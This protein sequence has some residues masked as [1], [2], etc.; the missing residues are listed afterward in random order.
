MCLIEFDVIDG[1][2]NLSMG[3]ASKIAASDRKPNE[4]LPTIYDVKQI[5]WVISNSSDLINGSK[6]NLSG[7]PAMKYLQALEL[8]KKKL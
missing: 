8:L 6:I 7:D 4:K 5:K 2:M 3:S 1:G